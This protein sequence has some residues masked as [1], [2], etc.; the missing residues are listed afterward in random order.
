VVIAKEV[1]QG[2]EI[3]ARVLELSVIV[4]ELMGRQVT[5]EKHVAMGVSGRAQSTKSGAGPRR[6][7][8][9]KLWLE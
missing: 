9:Q 7:S 4:R 3:I 2:T 1:S 6:N 5:D 8:E